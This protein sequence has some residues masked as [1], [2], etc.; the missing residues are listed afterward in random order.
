MPT[1]APADRRTSLAADRPGRSADTVA[2]TAARSAHA[3][4]V[5]NSVDNWRL[6]RG[7][8]APSR[9]HP[10]AA[11]GVPTPCHG[12]STAATRSPTCGDDGLHP[13]R[14]QR[15]LLLLDVSL[16]ETAAS[17]SP[18]GQRS[19]T[20]GPGR[21]C[22]PAS[23]GTAPIGRTGTRRVTTPRLVVRWDAR[24]R[25]G[26]RSVARWRRTGIVPPSRPSTAHRASMPVPSMF[27]TVEVRLDEVPRRPRRPR[28]CRRLGGEVVAEPAAGAGARR[29][30]AGG[31]RLDAD[32]GRVRLRG[33][34]PRARCRS[35]A[36]TTLDG[37]AAEAPAERVLVSGRLLAEITRALPAKP[38]DVAV[39]GPRVTIVGGSA[40]FTLP[41][42]PVE[43]YP[44]LPADARRVRHG[45]RRDV[46]RGRR[47]DRG[48]RRP[49]RH[50]ADADRHPGRDR[51]R[52][53]HAGR[54]RPVPAGGPGAVVA[55]GHAGPVHRGAGAG[56]HP[57]RR[58]QDPRRRHRR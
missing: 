24:C 40:R 55:A 11:A 5:D 57:G 28:R 43:D 54:H 8:P 36:W 48:R 31:S 35:T 12:L 52:H 15:L 10:H 32:R 22:A 13:H 23:S 41:T 37:D 44:P 26:R 46:R 30:P 51:G 53:A 2:S 3:H 18:W 34:H 33:V 47:A 9:I 42:M 58:R 7:Q 16:Q 50:P 39:D 45:R 6:H 4:R 21:A 56:P 1:V 25:A 27:A 19:R 20:P 38:V 29:H 14:P 17:Q 49:R